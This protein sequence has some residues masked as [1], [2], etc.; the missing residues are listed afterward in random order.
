MFKKQAAQTTK[1][2][3]GSTR[4]R[5]RSLRAALASVL[6]L[7]VLIAALQSP[8]EARQVCGEHTTLMEKLENEHKE[9]QESM[10]I[11]TDGSLLEVFVSETGGWTML[12]TYPG[13]PTCVVA[14]GKDWHRLAI[15]AAATGEIS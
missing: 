9:N 8:A 11:A 6:S 10:G 3:A 5:V 15:P 2:P 13:R 7:V 1:S 12:V 4:G 14:T